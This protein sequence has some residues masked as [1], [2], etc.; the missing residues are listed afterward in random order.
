MMRTRSENKRPPSERDV[1]SKGNDS[2]HFRGTREY[3]TSSNESSPVRRG[4]SSSRKYGDHH[5][6]KNRLAQKRFRER[7]KR[8]L[9]E[10]VEAVNKL[11][12]EKT[13]LISTQRELLSKLR[14]KV[15]VFAV[16]EKMCR[17]VSS[18]TGDDVTV[19]TDNKQGLSTVSRKGI[20]LK[21]LPALDSKL[22]TK[23][24]D[25]NVKWEKIGHGITNAFEDRKHAMPAHIVENMKKDVLLAARI[26]SV[27]SIQEECHKRMLAVRSSLVETTDCQANASLE[28]SYGRYSSFMWSMFRVKPQL[29]MQWFLESSSD[30]VSVKYPDVAKHVY[31]VLQKKE[32]IIQS[33]HGLVSG[34][35]MAEEKC[36]TKLDLIMQEIDCAAEEAKDGSLVHMSHANNIL[37][38][39]SK[40]ATD[41]MVQN[42]QSITDFG[43]KF[44]GLFNTYC[45]AYIRYEL[46]WIPS[47]VFQCSTVY[48][49]AVH[50]YLLLF[51]S[52]NELHPQIVDYFVLAAALIREH[53]AICGTD[54]ISNTE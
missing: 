30:I 54:G 12:L 8:L 38:N 3:G 5:R 26:D 53:D 19:K 45:L 23:G 11:K 14:A 49:K 41:V 25:L 47:H 22:G 6:E 10:Q 20:E 50:D 1:S 36:Q 35:M 44:R 24:E 15:Q 46:H 33:L 37:E 42:F 32:E 2:C 43:M 17:F 4:S 13:G 29:F 28:A 40:Q 9:A 7:Q 21:E 27:A 16:R 48:Y 51:V 52:S 31:G 34:Y 18:L 39:C